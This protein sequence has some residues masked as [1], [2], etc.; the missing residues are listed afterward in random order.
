MRI[1]KYI[2]P[3]V[4]L[5]VIVFVLI[6][7]FIPDVTYLTQIVVDR[8]VNHSFLIFTNVNRMAD[9]IPG[10]KE[11]E[12]IKSVPGHVGSKY[13]LVFETEGEEIEM[14]EEL[15]AYKENELFA[16]ILSNEVI[17]SEVEISFNAISE[18][19]TEITALTRARGQNWFWRSVFPFF[20]SYFKEQTEQQYNTLKQIIENAPEQIAV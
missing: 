4:L 20:K 1:L 8:P 15:T 14:I 16:F 9:W 3:A 2:L 5:L 10:F 17:L 12:T 11:I 7:V 13:R 6:G 18:N 19:E